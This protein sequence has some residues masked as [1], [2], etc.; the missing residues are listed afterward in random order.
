VS[1]SDKG[2]SSTSSSVSAESKE[3]LIAAPFEVTTDGALQKM[4]DI[5]N[6]K[7]GSGHGKEKEPNKAEGAE[8]KEQSQ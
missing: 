1:V 5:A 4:E 2:A 7:V 6:V 8:S 3:E